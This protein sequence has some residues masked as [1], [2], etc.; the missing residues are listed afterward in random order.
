MLFFVCML[1]ASCLNYSLNKTI[2]NHARVLLTEGVCPR[3]LQAFVRADV[4][5]ANIL[6]SIYHPGKSNAACAVLS[7]RIS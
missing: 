3:G 4:R 5:R 6:S 2:N 1:W 7:V